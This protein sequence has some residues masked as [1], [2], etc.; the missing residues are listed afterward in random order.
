MGKRVFICMEKIIVGIVFFI[1]FSYIYWW[2]R[3]VSD[4]VEEQWLKLTVIDKSKDIETVY[5]ESYGMMDDCQEIEIYKTVLKD[6]NGKVYLSNDVELYATKSVGDKVKVKEIIH[7]K[8]KETLFG[9]CKYDE[10][11][12]SPSIFS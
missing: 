5:C 3:N 11:E 10:V 8:E 7:H 2:T 9:K 1:G 6:E 12:Y 4:E